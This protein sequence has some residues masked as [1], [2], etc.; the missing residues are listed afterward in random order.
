M[1]AQACAAYCRAALCS[2]LG[3]FCLVPTLHTRDLQLSRIERTGDADR[4]LGMLRQFDSNGCCS[5]F[6]EE[7]TENSVALNQRLARGSTPRARPA[8]S[9][10]PFGCAKETT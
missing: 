9:S 7:P 8:G 5:A 3:R 10:E 2:Y 1:S 4:L 6:P